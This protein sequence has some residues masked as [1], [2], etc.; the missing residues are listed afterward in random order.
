MVFT[1][2]V[3]LEI[4]SEHLEV[5]EVREEVCWKAVSVGVM[6]EEDGKVGVQWEYDGV[7][8]RIFAKCPSGGLEGRGETIKD[9]RRLYIL[10]ASVEKVEVAGPEGVVYDRR[11][12]TARDVGEQAW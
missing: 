5:S 4:R 10:D 2:G 12:R 6:S 1:D 3:P 11:D 8:A 9:I 7:E